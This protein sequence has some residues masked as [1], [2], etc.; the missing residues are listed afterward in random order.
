MYIYLAIF[1]NC[2]YALQS[3]YAKI[4]NKEMH[5]K[6][7]TKQIKELVELPSTS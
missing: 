1:F 5:I 7:Y 6:L 2:P 4:K 3:P